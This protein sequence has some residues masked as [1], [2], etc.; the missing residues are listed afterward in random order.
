MFR[1]NQQSR[2]RLWQRLGLGIACTTL[3]AANCPSPIASPFVVVATVDIPFWGSERVALTSSCGDDP[4]A[5]FHDPVAIEPYTGAKYLVANYTDLIL[6]DIELG[7]ACRFT[8]DHP[9][10]WNPTGVSYS[11]VHDLV[12][13]ANYNGDNILIFRIEGTHL[14]E[15]GH[16]DTAKSPE[17]VF[18]SADGNRLAVA[19]YDAES[20][21][22]FDPFTGD[23]IW[24]QVF[25]L[26]H[27][28]C[29]VGDKLYGTVLFDSSI[30]ECDLE[31][32]EVLRRAGTKG[33]DL[34]KFETIWP[35]YIYPYKNDQLLLADGLGGAI[36]VIDRATLQPVRAFGKNGPTHKYLVMPYCAI[37]NGDAILVCSEAQD[38]VVVLIDDA[39]GLRAVK[40]LNRRPGEW[41]YLRSRIDATSTDLLPIV[42]GRYWEF[43]AC[44]GCWELSMFGGRYNAG[45]RILTKIASGLPPLLGGFPFSLPDRLHLANPHGG[46]Y[47][48]DFLFTTTLPTKK[49]YL[50][51]SSRHEIATYFTTVAGIPY[52][53][54]VR[55]ERGSWVFDGELWGPTTTGF[56]ADIVATLDAAA[57]QLAQG[58]AT[59]GYVN[60]EQVRQALFDHA[61]TARDLVAPRVGGDFEGLFDSLLALNFKSEPGIE[62]WNK[63][64]GFTA[65]TPASQMIQ[66]VHAYYSAVQD[67]YPVYLPEFAL[68]AMLTGYPI[69]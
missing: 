59:N 23:E 20:I 42:H 14:R 53:L 46:L 19:N 17:G 50:F 24:T 54:P 32:G 10:L 49:G 38:R 22:V 41:D 44:I 9:G 56:T 63:Y 60:P 28:V 31:T 61:Y 33:L 30:V 13:V 25:G 7:T 26:C 8:H 40:S 67:D 47:S 3:L 39:D 43:P 18:I 16:I 36:Y 66:A 21:Q 1:T 69:Q 27:G 51:V 57:S 6:L 11:K 2:T 48:D 5:Y 34:A 62:F 4:A 45:F 68:V 64:Q 58:R 65:S 52:Y 12:Y 35:T 29:I 15:V 55:I 37:G